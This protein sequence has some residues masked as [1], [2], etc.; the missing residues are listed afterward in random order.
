MDKEIEKS[1]IYR[2]IGRCLSDGVSVLT[3]SFWHMILLVLPACLPLSVFGTATLF[4]VS[5]VRCFANSVIG[6]DVFQIIMGILILLNSAVVLAVVYRLMELR[7]E[8]MPMKRIRMHNV[9][10]TQLVVKAA[11]YLVAQLVFAIVVGVFVAGAWF[12]YDMEITDS[13]IEL[14][15]L[16][17]SAY[18]VLALLLIAVAAPLLLCFPSVQFVKGNV[19]KRIWLGYRH[20]WRRWGKVFSLGLLSYMIVYIIGMLF[21][22][23][24]VMIYMERVVA[25]NSIMNGEGDSL[26]LWEHIVAVAVF[27]LVFFVITVLKMIPHTASTYMYL[28][29]KK[30]VY[31]ETAID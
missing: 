26:M 30:D 19:F 29:C 2:N 20:G 25:T 21:A 22:I 13:D 6:Q 4:V 11:E 5:D 28:N 18:V 10:N 23:A 7:L 1:D 17:E 24:M 3:E 15:V 12:A 16:Q 9:Y 27:L 31:E 14:Q 8:G